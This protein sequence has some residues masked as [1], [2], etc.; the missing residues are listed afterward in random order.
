MYCKDGK[1]RRKNKNCFVFIYFLK[2]SK[3]IFCDGI[4]AVILDRRGCGELQAGNTRHRR[5]AQKR[6]RKQENKHKDLKT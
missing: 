2:Y 5:E 6:G 1:D 3:E 4:L